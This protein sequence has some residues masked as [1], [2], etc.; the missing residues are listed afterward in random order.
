MNRYAITGL[1]IVSAQ[2]IGADGWL[3]AVRAG[4]ALDHREPIESFDA[5]RYPGARVAEVRNFD[6]ASFL[7]EKGLR[8]LDRLTKMIVVATRQALEHAGIKSGGRFISMSP[9]RV[10]FCCSNAHGSVEAIVETDR[11]ALLEDPR[12]INPS[13]FPNTVANSAAGYA[14]IWEDLRALNVAVSN[15]NCGALDTLSCADMFFQTDR[16]DAILIGGA[17]VMHEALYM[18]F[19][20]A[21][22][23]GPSSRTVLGEGAAIFCLEPEDIAADRGAKIMAYVTGYGTAF[24]APTRASQVVAP[25][26]E[27]MTR[28][29]LNALDAAELRP[30]DIDMVAS[31]VCGFDLMDTPEKAAIADVFGD[32]IAVCAPKA[33]VGET[34]GASGAMAMAS[35]LGWMQ[36]D[37]SVNF[38]PTLISGH[39]LKS[40]SAVLVTSIGFYGNASAVVMQ[41]FQKKI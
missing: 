1:G 22:F 19:R 37:Q 10:G 29:I 4:R 3:E 40:P 21:G 9:T 27:A 8:T 39:F 6:P 41:R 38:A 13:K 18:A 7:G 20:R 25:S 12:Y 28:A 15:G 11:I 36:S 32:S 34:L 17:E 30:S 2:A 23:C 31:G 5:A 24:V 33:L 14:S 26:K 35:A 16:A